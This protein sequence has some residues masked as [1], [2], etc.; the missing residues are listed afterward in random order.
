MKSAPQLQQ[1]RRQKVVLTRKWAISIRFMLWL[2][3]ICII[4]SFLGTVLNTVKQVGPQVVYPTWLQITWNTVNLLLVPVAAIGAYVLLLRRMFS[5]PLNTTKAWVSLI[6]DWG[7]FFFWFY[8]GYAY[9][10]MSPILLISF[11]VFF[12]IV[13]VTMPDEI[14]APSAKKVDQS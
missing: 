10:C 6:V 13:W 8:I 5:K 14:L 1:A 4:L 11:V 7:V 3:G 12:L 9:G 2:L